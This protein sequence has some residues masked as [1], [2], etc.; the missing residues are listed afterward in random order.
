MTRPKDQAAAAKETR[1]QEAIAA[2]KSKKYTCYSAAKA[3][4]VPPRTASMEA[5]NHTI[6]PMNAIKTSPTLKKK[7]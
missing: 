3:F 5:K 6:K 4:G 2:V 7:S 1:L